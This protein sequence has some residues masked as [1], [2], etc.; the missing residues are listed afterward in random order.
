MLQWPALL[1]WGCNSM[2][3]Q[4]TLKNEIHATGIGV[5]SGSKVY[6][7]LRPAPIDTGV[8]FRRVDL[9]PVVNI[10][11]KAEFI[12]DTSL[13]T[14]LA[15]DGAQVGTVEHLLSALSGVGIDNLY[16]DVDS[17]ELPIMDGSSGPFV[18]LI[19]SAGIKEQ[20]AL[21]KFLKVK[22]SVSV[23]AGDKQVCVSPY[24]GFKV[25]FEIDYGHPVFTGDN[26]SVELDFSKASYVREV[27]RARTFGFISDFEKLRNNSLALGASL[28]NTVALDKFKVLNQD[29]LR[30][31]DEFV[32]HKVLDVIGDLY[33]LG[34]SMI[35]AFSGVKSGHEMNN[36]LLHELLKDETAYEIVT[37]E[38]NE[39]MPI[40]FVP[41]VG[42]AAC[43]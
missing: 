24:D 34:Y 42:Q 19:Q 10:P 18:F 28:D 14:C 35:G 40:S 17:P 7:T 30:Y 5:H 1:A 12:S 3:K 8:V 9:S 39:K 31:D 36:K 32:K 4:R 6:L 13:C 38:D 15:R 11:A 25:K 27:S 29:G 41:L 23:T 20:D 2:I 26:Q 22:K 16:I 21:K 37:F 43:A 33:L